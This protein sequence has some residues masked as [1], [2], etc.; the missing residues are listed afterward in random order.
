MELRQLRRAAGLET[1][2]LGEDEIVFAFGPGAA[3]ASSSVD[4]SELAGHTLVGAR[5]EVVAERLAEPG[6]RC[7]WRSRPATRSCCARSCPAAS[8]PR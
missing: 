6:P 5:R 8:R 1:L 4:L 3:P 2:P 7:A